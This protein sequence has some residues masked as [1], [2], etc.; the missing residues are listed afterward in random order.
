MR[1][2]ISLSQLSFPHNVVKHLWIH[3]SCEVLHGWAAY[4]TPSPMAY[5]CWARTDLSYKFWLDTRRGVTKCWWLALFLVA[6]HFH[7]K[8]SP[9]AD[10]SPETRP[11]NGEQHPYKLIWVH[12]ERSN[13]SNISSLSVEQMPKVVMTFLG[14]VLI[15]LDGNAGC[16]EPGTSTSRTRMAPTIYWAEHWGKFTNFTLGGQTATVYQDERH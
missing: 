4:Y 3:A 13:Q 16:S 6:Q 10:S 2:T 15:I 12:I 5:A 9:N 8:Y 7:C 11:Q 14:V 1:Y